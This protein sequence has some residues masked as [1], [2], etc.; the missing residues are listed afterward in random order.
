MA[1][2]GKLV[3]FN[4]GEEEFAA[5]LERVELFFVANN[6]PADKKVPIF[7][8]CIGVTTYGLLRSLVAPANPKDKD[9][10]ELAATLKA[11]FEPK[12]LVIAE[13][14][15]FH[16]R[17]QASGETVA[18]Y[19]AVLRKLAARCSFGTYLEEALRDRLVCGLREAAQKKLLAEADLTLARAV[20][21]AKGSEAALQGAHALKNG[22]DPAV[23]AVESQPKKSG[24]KPCYRCG[25]LGHAASQCSFREAV[26]HNCGK[27]GHIARVCRGGKKPAKRPKPSTGFS[28]EEF[29]SVVKCN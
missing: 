23:G 18:E 14:F 29:V 8:N 10:G 22:G 3:E 24:G 16:K 25:K 28:L 15:H 11:H 21:I 17:S 12:H 1:T 13:R 7:L 27:K 26:C 4:Q 19:L 9:L 5:Y 6:I 20:D 2:Y